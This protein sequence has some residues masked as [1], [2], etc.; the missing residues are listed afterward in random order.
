M[1]SSELKKKVI[2][3]VVKIVKKDKKYVIKLS[4]KFNIDYKIFVKLV[5][6]KFKKNLDASIEQ[7]VDNS[8]LNKLLQSIYANKKKLKN[9]SN[10]HAVFLVI[11]DIIKSNLE[12]M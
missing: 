9:H 8:Q 7:I 2:K 5:S 10:D 3:S 6:S 12:K 1:K 4:K 11:F